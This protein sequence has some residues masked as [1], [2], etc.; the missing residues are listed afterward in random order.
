MSADSQAWLVCDYAA[1][2]AIQYNSSVTRSMD[3]PWLYEVIGTSGV[4]DTSVISGVVLSA[5]DNVNR[6]KL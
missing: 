4:R 3:F 6:R 1:N 2:C 5:I